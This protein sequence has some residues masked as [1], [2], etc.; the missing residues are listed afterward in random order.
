M[1]AGCIPAPRGDCATLRGHSHCTT[2]ARK[3]SS[4]QARTCGAPPPPPP[5]PAAAS[6]SAAGASEP[7]ACGRACQN[8][9]MQPSRS[10]VPTHSFSG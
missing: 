3:N 2:S 8:A 7:D 6:A 5:P 9:S 10:G 1:L 4:R